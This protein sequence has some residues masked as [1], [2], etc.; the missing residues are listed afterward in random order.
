MSFQLI[1][2]VKDPDFVRGIKRAVRVDGEIVI[3][4]PNMRTPHSAGEGNPFHFNDMTFSDFS[5]LLGRHFDDFRV[6]GIGYSSRNWMRSII[7]AM[8]YYQRIGQL[9]RRASRIKRVASSAMRAT[10][11]DVIEHDVAAKATD[12]LAVCTNPEDASGRP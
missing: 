12:L 6:L 11:F 1:E 7:Q 9:L 8:P 4:T 10:N 3:T 5:A 2:H